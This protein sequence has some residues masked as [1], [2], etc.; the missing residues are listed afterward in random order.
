MKINIPKLQSGGGMPPFNYYTPVMVPDTSAAAG[1]STATSTKSSSGSDLDDKDILEMLAKIDGL[2]SDTQKLIS[3]FQNLYSSPNLFGGN[4]GGLDSSKLASAYLQGLQYVK[5]ANFNKK[6][7]DEIQ[8]QV[9]AQ[10][11]LNEI[12]LIDGGVVVQ[13]LDSKEITPISVEDYLKNPK[14]YSPISNAQLLKMRAYSSPFNNDI[15]GI[16]GN[17]IGMPQI[18]K[19]IRDS[20]A[21]LG[22]STYSSDGYSSKV[23]GEVEAGVKF[24]QSAYKAG[25][26]LEG[27]GIDGLYKSNILTK[28]QTEQAYKAVSYIYQMLPENAKTLLKVKTGSEQGSINLIAS[29][30][31]SGMSGESK[32]TTNLEL[33]AEGRK[34][35]SKKESEEGLDKLKTNVALQ[36]VQGR[37]HTYDFNIMNGTAEA[38]RVKAHSLPIITASGTPIGNN[39]TLNE[40]S[41][42]MYSGIFDLQNASMG[43]AFIQPDGHQKVL[44]E[45]QANGVDLP[46]DVEELNTSGRIKPD[47]DLLKR[48][49]LADMEI[50]KRGIKEGDYAAM[51]EVYQQAGLPIKYNSDGSINSQRWARFG[52]FNATAVSQAFEEDVNYS[53]A[54]KVIKDDNRKNNLIEIFKNKNNGFTFDD[55]WLFGDDEFIDGVVFVPVKPN[56][57]NALAGSG[58][59]LTPEQSHQLD[60][61]QKLSDK[62]NRYQNPGSFNL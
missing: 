27:M 15:L 16:V 39:S 55:G 28:D 25:A 47:L 13:D 18:N 10:G 46:I 29:L 57:F 5:T 62:R 24:L 26:N 32:F 8:K 58:T 6:Q 54:V 4:G 21:Q 3:I 31:G 50:R 1:A 40:L 52:A 2:P 45:G 60:T 34:P 33:D 11:G 56:A 23:A 9:I 43:E 42:S 17:G 44:I 37:G 12:A 53:G 35:G 36:F 7:Y 14:Q 51:N 41:S 30:V 61:I 49:E 38:I 19:L 48:K 20:L 22:T 59:T